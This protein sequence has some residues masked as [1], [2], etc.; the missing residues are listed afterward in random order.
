MM[1]LYFQSRYMLH[2]SAH[3]G[4]RSVRMD[5]YTV[6]SAMSDAGCNPSLA[7]AVALV[8]HSLRILSMDRR[9]P[10]CR[11]SVGDMCKV[12]EKGCVRLK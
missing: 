4:D 1:E 5:L 11:E 3:D 8:I 12:I 7:A 6:V 2:S 10:E 9:V